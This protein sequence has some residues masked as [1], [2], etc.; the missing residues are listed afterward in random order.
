MQTLVEECWLAILVQGKIN[1]NN[2][3]I[4][5]TEIHNIMTKASICQEDIII[6]NFQAKS[7]LHVYEVRIV[8]ITKIN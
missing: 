2:E 7:E 8:R 4:K 6:L 3:N 5:N 1:F